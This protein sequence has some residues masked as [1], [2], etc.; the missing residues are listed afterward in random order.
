ML[1]IGGGFL[2]AK[3][4]TDQSTSEAIF[5]GLAALI[6]V[7]WG[8]YHRKDDPQPVNITKLSLYLAAASILTLVATGCAVNKQFAS[9]TSTNTN[10]VQTVTL[11][12]S[13]TFAC[14]DAKTVIDKTRASAGKTSSVGAS[15]I[16]E[17][18]TTAGIATN[19]QALTGLMQALRPT[20]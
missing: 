1:K 13:V 14:G 2:V 15:G 9:T 20:P 7:V 16:N 3:G 10:G 4:I 6:G 17:E 19:I 8:Y 11:A 5:S 12:K 18:A